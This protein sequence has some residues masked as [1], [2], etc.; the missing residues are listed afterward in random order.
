MDA[1]GGKKRRQAW[2][3]KVEAVE[4]ASLTPAKVQQWKLNFVN[5][6]GSDPVKQRA[7]RISANTFLRRAKSLFAPNMIKHLDAARIPTPMPFDG[8]DFYKR[9]SIRYHGDFDV[10]KLIGQAKAELSETEPEQFKIFLLP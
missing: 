5:R 7:A 1:E 9:V 3:E 4:L 10:L 2:R 8:V 6:A